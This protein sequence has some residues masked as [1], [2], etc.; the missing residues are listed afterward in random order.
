VSELAELADRLAVAELVHRYFRC[1]DTRVSAGLIECLA[2]EFHA[3]HTLVGEVRGRAAFLEIAQRYYPGLSA[4]QHYCSNEEIAISG[5]SAECRSYL[6][7]QHVV[8][9]SEGPVLMPGGGRY[10]H[11]LI[12]TPFGWRI[13][14]LRND[15]TWMHPGLA[16]VFGPSAG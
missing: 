1:L 8:E 10:F 5:D 15:V 7:A 2:E 9:T 3:Y 13:R 14:A 16:K 4:M 11:E 12:R 6:F